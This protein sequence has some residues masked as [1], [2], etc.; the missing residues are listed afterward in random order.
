M[1]LWILNSISSRWRP[2]FR[3]RQD[4]GSCG[5][6]PSIVLIDVLNKDENTINDPSHSGPRGGNLAVATMSLGALIVRRR[7]GQHDYSIPDRHFSVRKPPIGRREASC[8]R[9]SK[10]FGQPFQGGN[11]VLISQER[12]HVWHL[13]LLSPCHEG[14]EH[15]TRPMAL[16]SRS[17]RRTSE[18]T[19][20]RDFI[21]ASPDQSR[22]E[23]RY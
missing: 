14:F 13:V 21:P 8:L 18:S 2:I 9:E 15:Q 23:T 3:F 22:C 5:L 12:N 7:T 16:P 4:K 6:S 1:S 10:H 19:R 20:R 17:G 11:A